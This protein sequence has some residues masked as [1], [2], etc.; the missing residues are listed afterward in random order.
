[1]FQAMLCGAHDVGDLAD[2]FTEITRAFG[3]DPW[4]YQSGKIHHTNSSTSTWVN[5]SRATVGKADV[6]VFVIF[7]TYGEIT[8]THELQEALDLGKPFV[9]MAFEGSWNRYNNFL[10][11]L[12]DY[13]GITSSDDKKMVEL[14]RMITSDYQIT[15]STFTLDSFKEKLRGEFSRLFE[16]G[17]RLIGLRNQRAELL[18]AAE[19]SRELSHWQIGKLISLAVD[20]GEANKM[21]RKTALRRLAAAGIRDRDLVTATCSSREQGVQRLAFDVLPA[22]LP[23]PPDEDLLR[24]LA[25]IASQ[26][27]DVGLVRRLVASMPEISSEAID[28]VLDASGSVDE[29]ARRRAFEGV[30]GRW[31][32]ILSV[33]GNERMGEFLV[34]CEGKSSSRIRWIDRLRARKQEISPVSVPMPR[35]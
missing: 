32:D 24:E 4:F 7:K 15:V 33:W 12:S 8:W 34:A 3:G 11:N 18:S 1:M 27:D 6:C 29:G 14:L 13:S 9:V 16:E 22:L 20:E 5:N 35:E 25:Q 28:V 31:D 23:L 30:D 2:G 17:V 10:H 19:R 21:W 26:C